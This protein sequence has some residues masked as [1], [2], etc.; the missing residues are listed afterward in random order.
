M[1]GKT[2]YCVYRGG[3]AKGPNC[4]FIGHHFEPFSP[5]DT[6]IKLSSVTLNE[7]NSFYI[8]KNVYF[9]N[10]STCLL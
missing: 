8:F 4:S 6:F 2:F 5:L 1:S 9:N 3:T 10:T 7:I